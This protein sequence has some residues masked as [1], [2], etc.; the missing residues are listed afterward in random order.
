MVSNTDLTTAEMRE[1]YL[2]LRAECDEAMKCTYGGLIVMCDDLDVI[3]NLAFEAL[4]RRERE[5]KH[6]NDACTSCGHA[7]KLHDDLGWCEMC[8]CEAFSFLP[9][10]PVTDVEG[11]KQT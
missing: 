10:S 11:N 6:N 3:L 5:E 7:S 8:D 9:D 1:K 4:A 2:D